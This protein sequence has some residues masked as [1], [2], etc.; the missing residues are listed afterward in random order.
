MRRVIRVGLIALSLITSIWGSDV[1]DLQGLKTGATPA[2]C[3]K[4]VTGQVWADGMAVPTSSSGS[5]S[6]TGTVTWSGSA[7][8]QSAG[9]ATTTI[10]SATISPTGTAVSTTEDTDN[11]IVTQFNIADGSVIS[12][13]NYK[14]AC[15]TGL[16][17]YTNAVNRCASIGYRLPTLAETT[18]GATGGYVPSCGSTNTRT[19]TA[20]YFGY[21]YVWAGTASYS[22]TGYDIYSYAVRCVR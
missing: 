13:L 4:L 9:S 6:Q 15:E 7:T 10:S 1:R 5:M 16:Y 18:G 12:T 21:H 3:S 19:S 11:I 20:T 22:G 2:C 8:T 14:K 17:T